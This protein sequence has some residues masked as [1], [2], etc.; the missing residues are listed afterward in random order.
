M[1]EGGLARDSSQEED[2]AYAE[3]IPLPPGGIVNEIIVLFNGHSYRNKIEGH[4]V[5]N[6]TS[7]LIRGRNSVIVVDTRTA[8]DGEALLKGNTSH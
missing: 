1:A 3:E 4:T 2:S 5:A 6:C 7:T 8:W